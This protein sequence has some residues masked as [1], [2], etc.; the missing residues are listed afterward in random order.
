M[1]E[2]VLHGKLGGV[3]GAALNV[4]RGVH[5]VTQRFGN[6][7][8]DKTNAHSSCKEHAEPAKITVLGFLVIFAQFD[9]PEF[10]HSQAQDKQEE[11]KGR[12]EIPPAKDIN[13]LLVQPGGNKI[14][15]GWF[16]YPKAYKQGGQAHRDEK[17]NM[18][19]H[20]SCPYESIFDTGDNEDWTACSERNGLGIAPHN[21]FDR[22]CDVELANQDQISVL[23]SGLT[24][25]LS[26]G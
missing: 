10:T 2:A 19:T 12:Q 25:D 7:P 26:F 8:K 23:F 6:T 4:L 11:D 1:K 16:E 14:Q 9:R 22:I 15:K 24:H 3:V 21:L 13:D 18:F 20:T 17:D 5:V